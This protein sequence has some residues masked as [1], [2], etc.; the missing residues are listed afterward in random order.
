MPRPNL[1]RPVEVL[2]LFGSP[3]PE[4]TDAQAYDVYV[5]LSRELTEP[6][7][8]AA[9]ALAGEAYSPAGWVH[10]GDDQR[11]LVVAATT[12]EK[13]GQHQD[14]LKEIVSKIAANGEER[15]KQAVKDRD[16]ADDDFYVRQAERTRRREAAKGIKFD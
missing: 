10:V 2:K 13:V 8:D 16:A 11:H 4:E 6:E 7:Q 14:S 3:R 1:E 9:A 15:R 12:I 5:D